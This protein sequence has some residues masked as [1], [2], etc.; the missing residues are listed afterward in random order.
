VKTVVVTGSSRGIGLGLARELVARDCNVVV[1][2]RSA[3]AVDA[4]LTQ[5]AS[6]ARTL[7]VPCDVTD[8]DD[9]QALWDAAA[10]RF[11]RVDIWVNNAGTTTN[12]L[13]LWELG[14][15]EVRQT[16]ETNLLGTLFGMQ[17]AAR[18]MR[19]QGG[20][21]IFNVEGMG[22][23]G[24]R[25]G[26][27]QVGLLPYAC[28]K[29]AVGYLDQAFLRELKGSKVQICSLRPGI[30]VTEHLLHGSEHLSPERWEKTKKVFNIL[31]DR[32][33]TTT[34][35]LADRILRTTRTGTRIAWLSTPKI[36]WRFTTAPFRRRD[37]FA[38]LEPQ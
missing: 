27:V 12:P 18:G 30:N 5:L 15:D 4:A 38:G 23:R 22:S 34:P 13:P 17:V 37:L 1:S 36:A 3:E 6:P 26:E 10:A 19:A 28:T 2:G 20:G 24:P 25:R 33:E 11:G 8:A 14:S 9:V 29:A 31:G 7:G 35:F 32:P 21:Q 16:V